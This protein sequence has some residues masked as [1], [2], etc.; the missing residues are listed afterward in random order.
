MMISAKRGV[1]LG[2]HSNVIVA[3]SLICII[4]TSRKDA[5]T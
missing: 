4:T 5:L 1:F 3:A 2:L